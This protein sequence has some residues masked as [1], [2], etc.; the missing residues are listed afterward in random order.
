MADATQAWRDAQ[1]ALAR[2]DM[3][4]ARRELE[5][6][7]HSAPTHAMARI[8]LGG[9]MLANGE[10][11]AA[12][13]QLLAAAR[14]PPDDP[15]MLCRLA[16]ALMRVGETTVARDCLAHQAIAGCRHGPTLAALAHVHQMLGEH[17]QSL[18]TMDRARAC[19]MDSADFRYYRAIQLQFNG[20]LEE[21]GRELESC[22]RAGPSHGRAWLTRA[23]LRKQTEATHHLDGIDAQLARV[24]QGTEDHAALEFARYKELEDLGRL[25]EAWA[26][27]E[28]GNRIMHKR[29]RHDVEGERRVHE[30]LMSLCDRSTLAPGATTDDGGPR[31][32]FIV[33]MP[34]SGTTVLDRILGNHSQVASAGELADFAQQL[35]YVAD[36]PGRT[37]ID[38]AIL[39]RWSRIDFALIGRRY[40][41]QTRWR[42]AGAAHYVDKLPANFLVAG[43][44]AKALPQ[45]VILHMVRDPMDVCF[46]NFRALF[47]DAYGYS[48]DLDALAAH[49][50]LY[51]ELMRHWHEVVPGRILDVDYQQLVADPEGG[52]RRVLDFCGLRYEPQCGDLSRNTAPSATLSSAQVREP[53]HLRGVGAWRRYERQLQ[54]LA[55]RLDV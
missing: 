54:S 42:A 44:I 13:E 41:E 16:Q 21:A 14:S 52:A 28:R 32:I 18:A 12:C 10:L 43:L 30:R 6:V 27:L 45:A 7:L 37:L 34:R 24:A 31:P 53:V 35:R 29:V 38:H 25:D 55:A 39:D 49:H 15:A 9:V 8:L 19:G 2:R 20:R 47:G 33:G 48:Y 40:L 36:V 26:A 5:T 51:V 3:A 50:R 1:A 17:A 4:V 11:R 46:S 22:L 23:R